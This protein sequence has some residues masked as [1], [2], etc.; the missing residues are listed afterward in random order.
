MSG[1]KNARTQSALHE[2]LAWWGL[3][4]FTSDHDYF[5]WQRQHFSP[6][7]LTELHQ[8]IEHKRAGNRQD[9]IAFYDLTVQSK[10]YPVLY[11]QRYEYYEE[12]GRRVVAELGEAMEILD[13]G[14]GPGIL[15]TFYARRFPEKTFVG[16]DR[17]SAS[18]TL[19]RR[20]ADELGLRNIHFECVDIETD[21]FSRAY[22]LVVVTHALLQAEHDLGVPS[23][24]WRTFERAH[25]SQQQVAFEQRTGL[26]VRLDRLRS[27]LSEQGHMIVF[28]K[29]RQL[30]RRIPFQRALAARGFQ[31]IAP[32]E[33]I[34]Y[35]SVE[36]V[37]DDGPFYVLQTGPH[38]TVAWEESPEPDEGRVF[39]RDAV[40]VV[41][42]D[43]GTPL[44]ENHWHSAQRAWE[45]LQD[46]LVLQE[47]TSQESD[48]RQV[49]VERGS[50][51]GYHYLYCANTFDQRQLVIVESTQATVLD[52][53]YQ[54]IVAGLPK[55]NPR[56]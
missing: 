32:P 25:S 12:I 33:L 54:E 44:Y 16:V 31:Q 38:R 18:I 22:D 40:P 55:R 56:P 10:I 7:D 34:R 45:Q 51:A 17:S 46:R 23:Q 11:S 9:E 27:L 43:P 41:L 30:A 5:A 13:V 21:P 35:R 26:G 15:T 4:H 19:A 14:C 53:Y 8:L 37:V 24:T 6:D 3:K 50:V 20:K 47:S 1:E 49:H 52:Q 36:E 39:L 29:V 42:S 2:H 28:E 48:G